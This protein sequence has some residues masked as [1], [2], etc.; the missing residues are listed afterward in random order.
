MRSSH[1][2]AK[3]GPRLPQLEEAR[4]QQQRPNTAKNK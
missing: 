1:T 3:S 2:E 4:T